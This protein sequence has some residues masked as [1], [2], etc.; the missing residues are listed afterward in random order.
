MAPYFSR[1]LAK[2]DGY[3]CGDIAVTVDCYAGP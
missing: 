3:G 2:R 1:E